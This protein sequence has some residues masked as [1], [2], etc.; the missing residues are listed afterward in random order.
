MRI[1]SIAS[2]SSGNCVYIGSESTHLLIDCGVSGK[3]IEQ[4]L[5]GIGLKPDDID[6][7]LVTHE[8][9]DH[10]KGLGV[11][12]RRY[13]L[14]LYTSAKTFQAVLDTPGTGRIDEKLL[15][16]ICAD[17]TFSIGDLQISPFRI[18]HDAADPMG[19]RIRCGKKS[20]AVAT[21]MGTY[22]SYIVEKLLGLDTILIESNHD[23]NMLEVGRYPYPLKQRILGDRGH[24]SNESAGAL[25]N[26]ILHDHMKHIILGHLSAENNYPALAYETVCC[27]VTRADTPYKAADFDIRV[28]KRDEPGNIIEW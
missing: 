10:I 24:L 2:G 16:A 3:K 20:A 17:R 5:N 22:D 1:C 27:E 25:L 23:V 6:A 18:S 19:F 14:P 11:I 4:G 8:H 21:D 7:V 12:S 9:A 28:A 15:H 26:E 13:A